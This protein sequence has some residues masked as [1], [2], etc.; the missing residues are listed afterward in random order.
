[1]SN[2][3]TP[4]TTLHLA[5]EILPGNDIDADDLYAMASTLQR[6]LEELG[7]FDDVRRFSA[8]TQVAGAKGF[9]AAAGKLL[10][11]TLPKSVPAL[12]GFLKEWALRP[13]SR[14]VSIEVKGDAG[15][16]KVEFDPR[17]ISATDTE[18]LVSTL[19]AGV[20]AKT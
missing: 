16:A 15:S 14:P 6:E 4:Q 1:M 11:D 7:D 3:T 17:T 12:V 19:L 18:K 9:S 20:K 2:V 13:G 10:L 8:E 5:V